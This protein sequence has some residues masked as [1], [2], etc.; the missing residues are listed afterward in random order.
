MPRTYKRKVYASR[1]KYSVEQRYCQCDIPAI[2]DA[3]VV[4]VPGATFEGM[5]KVK[6]LTVTLSGPADTNVLWAIVYNP[7]G[8]V[9]GA[10]GQIGAAN[11]SVNVYNPNQFV[12]P[13]SLPNSS[14]EI[15]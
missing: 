4:M 10:L 15:L 11:T 1:D 13:I 5:R 14:G 3:Q 9:P 6:H 12:L 8:V 2:G 7:A